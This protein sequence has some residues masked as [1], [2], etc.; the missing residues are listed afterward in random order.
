MILK[1]L[2]SMLRCVWLGLELNSA[3]DWARFEDAWISP[4]DEDNAL[5]CSRVA[6]LSFKDY[7]FGMAPILKGC[8]IPLYLQI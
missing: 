7:S 8:F 4:L 2:I 6:G 1:T 3:A 5:W